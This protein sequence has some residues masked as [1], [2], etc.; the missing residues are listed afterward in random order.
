M[1]L[2]IGGVLFE[3]REL[4]IK[5]I[6]DVFGVEVSERWWVIFFIV[7][8]GSHRGGAGSS[9]LVGVFHSCCVYLFEG[10]GFF[11]KRD[12]VFFYK[13]L[14]W[15]WHESDLFGFPGIVPCGIL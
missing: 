10:D 13:S 11:S 7:V 15:R 3:C 6:E 14:G 8:R 5:V 2:Q 4:G 1:A 12:D 9:E